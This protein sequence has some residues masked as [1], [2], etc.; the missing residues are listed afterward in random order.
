LTSRFRP[1]YVVV[2]DV[3]ERPDDIG[4]GDMTPEELEFMQQYPR[5]PE[6]RVS[7]ILAEVK[8]QRAIAEEAKRAAESGEVT[9][10]MWTC[11]RPD[12]PS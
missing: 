12:R 6:V 8:R 11:S 2:Q 10:A 5:I 7:A 4:G 1:L 9:R 3:L